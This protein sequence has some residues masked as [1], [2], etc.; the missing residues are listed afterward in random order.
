MALG[1]D[2]AMDRLVFIS[3]CGIS[4]NIQLAF[5]GNYANPQQVGSSQKCV[6]PNAT[7]REPAML[8]P[9]YIA[10]IM[11]TRSSVTTAAP[12]AGPSRLH[13]LTRR[14]ISASMMLTS[15]SIAGRT[16]SNAHYAHIDY[17]ADEARR[18]LLDCLERDHGIDAAMADQLGALL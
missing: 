13:D 3:S 15:A 6:P 18:H 1:I 9:R 16:I 10:E 4:L 7:G 5:F 14:A 2:K 11:R 12:D 8:R 17:A